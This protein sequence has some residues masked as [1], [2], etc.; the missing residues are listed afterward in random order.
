MCVC[1]LSHFSCVQLFA[2]LWTV[3]HEAPLSKGFSEQEYWSVLLCSPPGLPDP[4]I[5]L[6]FLTFLH[7][8]AVSLPLAPLYVLSCFCGVQLFVTLWTVVCQIPLSMGF[9]RQEYWNGL[10]QGIFPTQGSNLHLLC[11]LHCRRVFTTS[12]TWEAQGLGLYCSLK[13]NCLE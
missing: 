9:S 2:N 4:G 8:Q 12:A 6:M 5:E 1:M 10:L 3:A 13:S 7:W 11:L